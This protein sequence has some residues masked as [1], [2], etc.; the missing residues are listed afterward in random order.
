MTRNMQYVTDADGNKIAAILPI[1]EYEGMLEDLHS[2]TRRVRAE[3]RNAS[4]G[5]RFVRS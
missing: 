5:G 1:E 4:P 2:P 3:V